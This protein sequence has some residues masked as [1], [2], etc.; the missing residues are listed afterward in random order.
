MQQ[1]AEFLITIG[2][3]L[4]LAL[5][6]DF[7]GKH[8]VL[9]RV[10]LLLIFG[11]I[12]G[13]D[14]L[15]LVPES[16]SGRFDLITI[17]ALLMV[18]FLLGGRLTLQSLRKDGR[19]V[20]WISAFAVLSTCLLVITALTAINVPLELAILLGCIATATAPVATLDTVL[21][22]GSKSKFS[23]LLL[24]IVALDDAWALLLFSLGLALVA[25]LSG[26]DGVVTPLYDTGWKI[27][28]S[29][30]LGVII[31]L[32]AAYMTGRLKPGQPMLTE[33]LGLVFVCGGAAIWLGV[34]F[35]IAAMTM[36]AVIANLARHHDYPFHEIESIEWPFMALFF[37]LAGASLEISTL[38][39]MGAVGIVYI[40][41]R[42][43]GKILGAWIGAYAS[44]ANNEIRQ[45]M[46]VA[47]L[48]QAGVAIGMALLAADRFPEYEQ[49]I[50]SI[51]ISTTVV[52]ELFGPVFTRIAISLA[53][54]SEK[55]GSTK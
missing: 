9:P 11:I 45:W 17:L 7:L 10:S 52:F 32:P 23:Q 28:G 47:L 25:L 41:A 3:I 5:A 1:T 55:D 46:G 54:R 26:M 8:T 16:V 38:A 6:T 50:L 53:S 18:G 31:G 2:G 42:V 30:L 43:M 29:I 40:F 37:I 21:E 19:Q 4:L 15:A 51:V 48:P 44:N 22:S 39:A 12:I 13:D 35:I 20:I 24:A 34:S 36:G 49:T 14:A 27:L 33:A